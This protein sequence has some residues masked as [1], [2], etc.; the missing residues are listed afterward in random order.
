MDVKNSKLRSQKYYQA[1]KKILTRINL[2][3]PLFYF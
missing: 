1:M 2:D 3:F